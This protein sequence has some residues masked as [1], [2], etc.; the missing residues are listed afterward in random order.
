MN[1]LWANKI[2][3]DLS[4]GG[5]F[6]NRS[7]DSGTGQ[8]SM[9]GGGKTKNPTVSIHR[10]VT[11]TLHRSSN[12]LFTC[13]HYRWRHWFLRIR[14]SG[15][16]LSEPEAE[17][18]L[19]IGW[20]RCLPPFLRLTKQAGTPGFLARQDSAERALVGQRGPRFSEPVRSRLNPT[21]GDTHTI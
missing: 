3:W 16:Q 15:T 4:V 11:V 18:Q 6:D 19:H 17:V 1:K 5:H 9:G 14:V 20:F 7:S 12:R 10:P 13:A 2:S 8:H 21:W